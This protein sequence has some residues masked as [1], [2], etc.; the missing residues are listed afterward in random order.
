MTVHRGKCRRMNFTHKNFQYVEMDFEEF[1]RKASGKHGDGEECPCGNHRTGGEPPCGNHG[2][3]EDKIDWTSNNSE[4]ETPPNEWFYLRSLGT[5]PR[6]DV[7]DVSA[8]FPELAPDFVAP[9]FVPDGAFFSSVF[10]IASPG[11]QVMIEEGSL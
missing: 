1:V 10:R 4:E 9:P 3:G 5:D 11:M 6:K 2:S 8:G 7:S